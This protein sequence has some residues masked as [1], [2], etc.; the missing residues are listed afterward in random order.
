[1]RNKFAEIIYDKIKKDK[2]IIILSGDIGN[3][4]FNNIK[5]DFPK[6]F[7]NCGIAEQNMI[8]FATG[9]AS[10]GYIPIC[11]T[12]ST[13]LIYKTFE[14]IRNNAAYN[15]NRI[16]LVGTGS[17]L[18]YSQ[19]GTTH[20]SLE[21]IGIVNNI[22]S[23]NIFSSADSNDLK[24]HVDFSLNSK[25]TSYIR[26]GKKNEPIIKKPLINS[27]PLNLVSKGKEVALICTGPIIDLAIEIKNK[28]YPKENISIY[29]FHK[30]KPISNKQIEATLK[31][32]K[33]IFTLEEHYH[34]TGIFSILSN[35]IAQSRYNN[36]IIPINN[37]EDFI[38]YV[39]TRKTVRNEFGINVS[40][41]KTKIE[42]EIKNRN[43]F[44]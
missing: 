25:K 32:Y 9:L 34:N 13:F 27:N 36:K 28:I 24:K 19:L 1:M 12:I 10:Q 35:V 6:N 21:D 29:N 22:P 26:I 37:N 41:A 30:L 8:T 38:K 42:K 16:I 4:L 11:Y 39:G 40:K 43:R 14:Q 44:R 20:Y 18:S 17:G 5:K 33:Y 23:I 3:N 15:D 31:N 7:L 2:K